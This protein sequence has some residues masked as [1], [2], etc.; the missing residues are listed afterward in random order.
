MHR[1]NL[2]AISSL[3]WYICSDGTTTESPGAAVLENQPCS[4]WSGVGGH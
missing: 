4:S 2:K 1:G 3:P